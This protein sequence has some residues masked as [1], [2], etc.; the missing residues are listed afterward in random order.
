MAHSVGSRHCRRA[1]YL[2]AVFVRSANDAWAVGGGGTILPG[3]IDAPVRSST[4]VEL[5]A[6][7]EK[8]LWVV[9]DGG[10]ILHY[11]GREFSAIPSPGPPQ[12]CVRYPQNATEL[13]IGWGQR[14]VATRIRKF[15]FSNCDQ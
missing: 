1:T 3:L 2:R 7:R 5:W 9:G 10:T 15:I 6:T 4:S 14:Y 12:V 13:F 8:E 11:D